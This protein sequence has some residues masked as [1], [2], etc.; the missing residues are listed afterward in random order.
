MYKRQAFEYYIWRLDFSTGKRKTKQ[1]SIMAH[2]CQEC[3]REF[4]HRRNMVRHLRSVHQKLTAKCN[5]CGKSFN[6]NDYLTKH[7]KQHTPKTDTVKP[8]MDQEA[9]K[10]EKGLPGDQYPSDKKVVMMIGK[11]GD[12]I[13]W[14]ENEKLLLLA[15]TAVCGVLVPRKMPRDLA[16]SVLRIDEKDFKDQQERMHPV[17]DEVQSQLEV[18][19]SNILHRRSPSPVQISDSNDTYS[20][21]G[22][23][24]S[25]LEV[26]SISEDDFL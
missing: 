19:V 6:R 22:L 9:T 26:I 7:M 20:E 25:D 23:S 17:L 15:P 4:N 10:S 1:S 24:D 5:I 11:G 14:S 21:W 12:M 13:P 16:A 2:K 18:E 3:G 8:Q